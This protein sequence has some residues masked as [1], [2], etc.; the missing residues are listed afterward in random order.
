MTVPGKGGRPRKWRSDA[1]RQRAWRNRQT[2][3]PEP[4]TLAQALD[5]G[6]EL[7][8][9]WETIRDLGQQLEAAKHKAKATQAELNRTRRQHA[10]EDRRWG[11]LTTEN[12]HLHAENQRLRDERDQALARLHDLEHQPPAAPAGSPPPATAPGLSRA[13]R[14]R[15]EREQHRRR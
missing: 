15:L 2:G 1:D 6:D 9:A 10:T 8:R 13:A 4:P 14:R 11:W 7:A 3:L 12:Q 5:D